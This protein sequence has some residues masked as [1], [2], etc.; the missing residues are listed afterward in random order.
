M[1]IVE[2]LEAATGRA[3]RT[4]RIRDLSESEFESI[5]D[6]NRFTAT[7]LSNRFRYI[8]AHMSNEF[9]LHAFSPFIRDAADL[10]GMLS[11]S[12]DAGF[13]MAAVSET[14]PLFYGSI[15]D[16]VRIV[17]EEYG[18]DNLH[19]GDMILVNDY[20]RIGTHLNDACCIRPVF[21]D[22]SL[23]GAVTIRAHVLDI[24]GVA[25]GGFEMTKRTTYE[26]GLRLP[27]ILLYSQGEPVR[28][29]FKLLFDNSRAGN[30]IIP[31]LETE[32]RALELGERLVVE[33]IN[34]Y[35]LAAFSGAIRYVCDVSAEAMEDALESIPDG[36]YSAQQD[37]DGD[38]LPDSPKYEVHATIRVSG[39]RAEFDLRGSSESTRSA[40]NCTWADIKTAIAMALKLL[41]D[42][43][44]PVTSGTLRPVDV[45]VP[46][47]AI[48]NAAPPQPCHYYFEVVMMLVN[49][50]T[51]ALNP[52][53]G[54][55]GVSLVPTEFTA[56]SRFAD[57]QEFIPPL[58]I[59]GISTPWSASYRGDGDSSQQAVYMNLLM[60][61]G[62][63]TLEREAP[64]VILRTEY[65]PDT[66]GAGQHRGGA[67]NLHD[68]MWTAAMQFRLNTFHSQADNG[69]E[70]LNGGRPGCLAAHWL[71][72]GDT[73]EYGKSFTPPPFALSHEAYRSA[74]TL[75]G[76]V[77]PDTQ[78][79]DPNAPY[80]R[81]EANPVATE[82]AVLRVL[83]HGGGGWGD[84]YNRDP[85]LVREDVRD[86]YVS[87][88]AAAREYGVV[89]V[90]DPVTDPEG[91][92]VDYEATRKRR[93]K[94]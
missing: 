40:L 52:V 18:L 88:E 67:A 47:K 48:F 75:F 80:F 20:Y 8:V 10:C 24:G 1:T 92:R 23:V 49:A 15:P 53:V 72:D 41:I 38:G 69:G 66:A 9:R 54:V 3:G 61:S 37:I 35:G 2:Q 81:I 74:R 42:Q 78:E 50:I 5:Y 87:L 43:R 56:P 14:L 79:L 26:D 4:S 30:L 55:T 51:K 77:A 57:G 60:H 31:D 64:V 39:G 33:T 46:P 29:T 94:A 44:T 13:P 83:T 36:V 12:P 6:C 45:V 32:F 58:D 84:P 22:G 27:P 21:F 73:T 76:H 19:P 17:L 70:G 90:G 71:W 34:K 91:L 25:A 68:S 59:T 82:G 7:I 65:V 86:E 89:L 63:E 62:I 93:A 85:D 11:G 16:A 28:S